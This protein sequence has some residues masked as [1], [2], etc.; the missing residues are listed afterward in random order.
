MRVVRDWKRRLLAEPTFWFFVTG[1][2]LFAAHRLVVGDGRVIVLTAGGRAELARQFEDANGRA[3]TPVEMEKEIRAW[4]R[5]EALSREALR[6]GLD[7]NDRN[8]RSVLADKVR[9]RVALDIPTREPTA[10]ELD[11]WL[12]AHRSLYESPPRYDYGAI[13]FPRSDPSSPA[14]LARVEREIAAGAD[15]R[16]LGRPIVGADLGDADLKERLG[17]ALASRIEALPVG[18]WQ[19]LERPDAFLLARLN[20]VEGGLPPPDLL[21]PRLVADW[22]LAERHREI[23]RALQALVERYRLEER[24]R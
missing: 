9:A 20:A 19:R 6:A 18:K 5:D 13:A 15:P 12:A 2:L 16:M 4:E 24:A 11:A 8:V 3:P 23:E 10:A 14:E 17:P 1:A 21:H 22:Q 7:R